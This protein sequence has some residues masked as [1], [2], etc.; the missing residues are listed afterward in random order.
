LATVYGIVKQHNGHIV[1]ESAPGAGSTFSV[2]LPTTGEAASVH[3]RVAP[4]ATRK[5]SRL[6][7]V[8]DDEAVRSVIA[9][10][11]RRA[12]HQVTVVPDAKAALEA[13]G[14]IDGGLQLLVTDVVMP[15]MSGLELSRELQSRTPELKVLFFSGYPG[16]DLEA[17][18]ETPGADY[19]AKP[20]SP[21][22]LLS[23]IDQL[24]GST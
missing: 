12:G 9:E 4:V 13:A 24:L 10:I 22:E 18:T 17:L 14:S 6:L 11:L 15:G 19:L 20:V 8:D 5:S 23:R 21:T 1:V 2:Y 3:E 16:R 7:L